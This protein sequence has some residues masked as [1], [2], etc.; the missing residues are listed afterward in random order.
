MQYYNLLSSVHNLNFV[1]DLIY[2]HFDL[3]KMLQTDIDT[4]ASKVRIGLYHS[5]FLAVGSSSPL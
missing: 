5:N 2:G 3:K 1:H 4:S